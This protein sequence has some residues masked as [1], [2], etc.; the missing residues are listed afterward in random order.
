MKRSRFFFTDAAVER[1]MTIKGLSTQTAAFEELVTDVVRA[2][3]NLVCGFIVRR[4][5]AFRAEE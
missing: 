2:T 1:H 4:G 3:I 5:G